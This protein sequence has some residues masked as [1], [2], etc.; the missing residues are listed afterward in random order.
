MD[1]LTAG[2]PMLTPYQFASN[3]P[4]VA[5]DLDGLE[6]LLVHE[7]N[8]PEIH[9]AGK[10]LTDQSAIH[11]VSHGWQGGII[12]DSKKQYKRV[13]NS[14]QFKAAL[15]KSDQYK[16]QKESGEICVVLH[17]CRT[18]RPRTNA[19]GSV[20]PSFAEKMSKELEV[21]IIAP[22]QRA[23]FSSSKAKGPYR[24]ENT[25]D[26]NGDYLEGLSDEEIKNS[27]KEGR[28]NWLIYNKGILV[29]VY[30][31]GWSPKANPG[32]WDNFWYKKDLSYSVTAKA[33][34]LRTGAGAKFEINGDPL[35]KGSIL[36]PTGNV[37]KSWLEVKTKDGRS[38]WI[39]SKYAKP[40]YDEKG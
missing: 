15:K 24:T 28:G 21:K 33:L 29:D 30:D 19:D 9:S 14:R 11:V 8:D 18:G 16:A 3:T 32:S 13:T 2:Y 40:K 6:L 27:G 7:K 39:H 23:Y 36:T 26:V 4:I 1:P 38:G 35:E 17:S 34:N 20:T 5:I 22:D 12:D 10:T 31:G 25:D 37:D